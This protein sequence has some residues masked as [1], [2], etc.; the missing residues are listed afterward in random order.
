MPT[1]TLSREMK[2]GIYSSE[3]PTSKATWS[4][5]PANLIGAFKSIGVPM[6]FFSPSEDTIKPFPANILN[7][8]SPASAIY[9]R[10]GSK[11]LSRSLIEHFDSTSCDVILH[12]P[13][14]HLPASLSGVKAV[15][16][17]FL[18]ATFKQFLFPWF[19]ERYQRRSPLLRFILQFEMAR[20][21]RYYRSSLQ[22][23]SH[24]FVA[25]EWTRESLINDYAIAPEN[26]TVCY[27]GTGSISDMKVDRTNTPPRLLFVARHNYIAKGAKLL[28]NAFRLI[29][30]KHPEAELTIVGPDARDLGVTADEP[31]VAIHGFLPWEEL[32]LLFNHS[33]LFVMPSEYEPYGLVYLEAM[34]CGMPVICSSTGGMASIVREQRAGWILKDLDPQALSGLLDECLS[35]LTECH[36]RGENGRIFVASKCSWTTCAQTI[37]DQLEILLPSP[38]LK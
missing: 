5:T 37:K 23:I 8:L 9:S 28:L 35:D 25:S 33:T 20:R 31:Q 6:V 22:S 24:F 10:I 13:A 17:A 26:I 2:I 21:N 15:H 36:T 34:K 1:P 16:V 12:A 38:S 27:T 14:D 4:G 32:E 7:A 30:D 18:D 11:H 19:K 3:D 29:R